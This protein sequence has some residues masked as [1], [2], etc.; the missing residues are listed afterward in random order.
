M[1]IKM[2]TI[3]TAGLNWQKIDNHG[4][5][6]KIL[7][8]IREKKWDVT[9]LSEMHNENTLQEVYIDEFVYWY[10]AEWQLC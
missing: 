2:G 10:T 6:G 7:D 3:N 1:E 5:L 4:K 9:F 8:T